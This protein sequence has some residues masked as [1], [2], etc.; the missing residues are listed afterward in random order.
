MSAEPVLIERFSLLAVRSSPKLY[1]PEGYSAWWWLV[2]SCCAAGIVAVLWCAG[3]SLRSLRPQPAGEDQFVALQRE[4][5]SRIDAI[6][7]AH[8]MGALTEADVHQ[9]LSSEV[10]RFAGL[11]TGGDADY[12]VLSELRRAAVRDRRLEAV[13]D[14]VARTE[15]PAFAPVPSS[16]VAPILAA[17]RRVVTQ[18]Q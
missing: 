6:E 16:D 4:T 15:T 12:L 9:R 5:N 1:P 11:A 8:L 17:A 10:R 14:L 3:R 2:A 18:W 13:A 7:Q